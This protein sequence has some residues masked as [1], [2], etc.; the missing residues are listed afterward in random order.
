MRTPGFYKNFESLSNYT[1]LV[2]KWLCVCVCVRVEADVSELK[3]KVSTSTILSSMQS[4]SNQV[5]DKW[6]KEAVNWERKRIRVS[7]Q[8]HVFCGK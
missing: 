2:F 4:S 7:T 8:I 6:W 1:P 5:F 3:I